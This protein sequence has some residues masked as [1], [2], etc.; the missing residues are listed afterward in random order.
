[1]SIPRRVWTH[2]LVAGVLAA[3]VMAFWFLVIDASLGAPFRTPGLLAG[4]LVGVDGF[5]TRPG[6]IALYTLIHY[7][8]FMV[9]GVLVAW[10][11]MKMEV[12]PGILLGLLVGF[13]LFDIVFYASV[14]VTGIDVV[15]ELGWVEVLVGNLLAGMTIMAY[16]HLTGTVKTVTWWEVLAEHQIVREGLMAGVVGAA[17]VAFWFLVVDSALGRPLFTPG[18]LGSALFLGASDVDAIQVTVWTV[19][20]YSLVHVI[21]FAVLGMVASAIAWEAERTPALILGAL[22]LFVAFEA[23][24]LGLLAVVAEF[25]LGP[26]AWWT[27]AVGNVLAVIAMGFY[28]WKKHPALKEALARDPF[29]RT[30]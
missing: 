28:L 7:A 11:L 3:T 9:V 16:L 26:L 29:D 25:L 13:I 2:G 12:S 27:I 1:M 22:L 18:A 4:S 14:Y 10:T 23:F 5:E 19:L 15:A 20:G 24:F 21:A 17:V 8:A 6:L 30:A